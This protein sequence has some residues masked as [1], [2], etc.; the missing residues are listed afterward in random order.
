MR[1]EMCQQ[2][3]ATVHL[4]QAAE[5]QVREVHLCPDCAAQKGLDVDTPM[6]LTDFIFGMEMQAGSAE[7]KPDPVCRG[8]GMRR[9]DYQKRLRL[10]CAVCYETFAGDLGATLADFQKGLEHQGKI[11][12][13][14]QAASQIVMLERRLDRAVAEQAFEDAAVLRDRIRSLSGETDA[15]SAQEPSHDC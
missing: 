4:K 13:G 12:S 7:P 14:E 5:G 10:G 11:P 8:C 2:K 9:S 15:A 1:C 3:E 6:A